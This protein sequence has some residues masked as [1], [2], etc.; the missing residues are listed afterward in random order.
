MAASTF[1]LRRPGVEIRRSVSSQVSSG[2]IPSYQSESALQPSPPSD[3]SSLDAAP[4]PILPSSIASSSASTLDDLP[5]DATST[6]CTPSAG[7]SRPSHTCP[8]CAK[9]FSRPAK[10]QDHLLIHTDSRPHACSHADC[11]AAY[12]TRSKLLEHERKAH[13]DA[14]QQEQEKKFLCTHILESGQACGRRFWTNQHL[15]RHVE[16]VH[17]AGATDIEREEGDNEDDDNRRSGQYGCTEPGC[18]QAFSKRKRLRRHVWEAHTD[19]ADEDDTATAEAEAAQEEDKRAGTPAALRNK[20]PFPC[21]FPDCTKRFPTNSKRKSHFKTHAEDRYTCALPHPTSSEA[22]APTPAPSRSTPELLTFPTWS[23]LQSHM[24]E[25]HPPAC[26]YAACNGKVFKN[27]ENLKMHLRR[28]EEKEHEEKQREKDRGRNAE[29]Q[30]SGQGQH[31]CEASSD[32]EDDVGAGVAKA[33]RSLRVF[34]CTW[35]PEARVANGHSQP[36]SAISEST[37]SGTPCSKSFKSSHSLQT[38]IR[39]AHLKD[40]PFK[41]LCGKAYGHKHLLKRHEVKCAAVLA[42]EEKQDGDEEETHEKG[43]GASGVARGDEA[44]APSELDEDEE[45]D[46]FRQGGGALPEQ[47]RETV[48]AAGRRLL[49]GSA[50]S[51]RTSTSTSTMIASRRVKR[52]LGEVFPGTAATATSVG[53]S[54]DDEQGSESL[55]DLLTGR[56]Y[57]TNPAT[58]IPSSSD[59]PP[60]SLTPTST[61]QTRR[62]R[63]RALPCPWSRLPLSTRTTSNSDSNPASISAP[64]A[65]STSVPSTTSV[66]ASTD[67]STITDPQACPFRFARLYDVTRHLRGA[68]GV[69][70][71]QGEVRRLFEEEELQGLPAPRGS[72]KGRGKRIRREEEEEVLELEEEEG[73]E[74]GE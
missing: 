5:L 39:V 25:A 67:A 50:R 61:P 34:H 57:A 65:P 20:L 37:S 31:W 41:C 26:H 38:H 10:L 47:Y 71:S 11:N 29:V 72:G 58:T 30:E 36:G 66:A 40:R 54:G 48:F 16:G 4:L 3:V 59:V 22:L 46:V 52:K 70:L 7:T 55:I 64:S 44:S 69:E 45:D 74:E 32:E 63:P 33:S 28:H 15:L 43:A 24:R 23:A 13:L 68:H 19:H 14:D 1:R 62:K 73:E 53:A 49:P 9:A 27:R 21:S 12:R 2:L 42:R 8:H 17:D 51:T 56:G 6:S 60:S 18:T 35:R